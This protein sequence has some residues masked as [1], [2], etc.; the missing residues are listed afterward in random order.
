MQN[1]M[2]KFPVLLERGG[3]AWKRD[4]TRLTNLNE[5][6]TVF[7][8]LISNPV[9]VHIVFVR[10]YGPGSDTIGKEVTYLVFVFGQK[11]QKR[12]VV[13]RVQSV[14]SLRFYPPPFADFSS[15]IQDDQTWF[16]QFR[17]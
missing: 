11:Q 7:F 9:I 14:K 13:H 1:E 10:D 4:P 12:E 5:T 15:K 17:G 2:L 16:W 8:N 3:K 6:V